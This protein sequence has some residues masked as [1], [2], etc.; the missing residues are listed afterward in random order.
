MAICFS[1][2]GCCA[3]HASTPHPRRRET[4]GKGCEAPSRAS[5]RLRSTTFYP[6]RRCCLCAR[7]SP[8][9][10]AWCFCRITRVERQTWTN[11]CRF[12]SPTIPLLRQYE[13]S[14]LGLLC[15]RF[16]SCGWIAFPHHVRDRQS[17]YALPGCA[18]SEFRFHD[19]S[20]VPLDHECN[21]W[22]SAGAI[23]LLMLSANNASRF[24]SRAGPQVKAGRSDSDVDLNV[25]GCASGMRDFR[26]SS[27]RGRGR[28][29]RRRCRGACGRGCWRVGRGEGSGGGGG[30]TETAG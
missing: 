2:T 18:H 1:G 10:F 30:G 21:C 20:G 16:D 17:A 23:A 4:P 11:Q 5:W 24:T 7:L 25:M 27:R 12:Q 22:V 6:L 28:R 26:R 19:R 3:H 14:E 13:S 9:D 15:L 29:R 8:N